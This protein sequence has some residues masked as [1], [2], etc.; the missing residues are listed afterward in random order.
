LACIRKPIRQI[1]NRHTIKSLNPLRPGLPDFSW[2][3]HQNRKNVLSS[4]K[5]SP[6]SVKYSKWP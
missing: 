6:M 5:I 3:M 1:K 2:Y 4:H